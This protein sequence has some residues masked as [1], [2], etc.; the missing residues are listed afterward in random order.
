MVKKAGVKQYE[1]LHQTTL[2]KAKMYFCISVPASFARKSVNKTVLVGQR[3][4]VE[5]PVLGDN[6]IK[7]RW[8]RN[9]QFLPENP[10]KLP[11]RFKVSCWPGVNIILVLASH[12]CIT[13]EFLAWVN[14]NIYN[15]LIF[16]PNCIIKF[17]KMQLKTRW[18]SFQSNYLE[19]LDHGQTLSD[20]TTRTPS[21][22]Q[23]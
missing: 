18:I 13:T 20:K 11:Q 16:L 17:C 9:Q 22:C 19:A 7:I 4:T 21:I 2:L 6:P 10:T 23:V 8:L 3:A 5:C 12:P 14:E 15:T 1:I